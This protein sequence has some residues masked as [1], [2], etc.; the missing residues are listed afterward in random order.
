MKPKAR[1]LLYPWLF[2]R[3]RFRSD[4]SA[5]PCFKVVHAKGL[6]VLLLTAIPGV[7]QAQF[8]YATNDN[9]ITITGYTGPGGNVVIPSIIT[10]LPVTR[11]GDE[12]FYSVGN[13]LTNL[14]GVS[15]PQ[16]VT[17]IGKSAFMQCAGLT[18][19]NLPD[20][21]A[22][23]GDQAFCSCNSLT[24]LT[25]GKA[26]TTIRAGEGLPL[27]GTFQWCTSL[28]CLTI[29]DNVTNITDGYVHLGGSL[30]A[31][32]NCGL[33]N[34]VIGKGLAY[35]GT[36][37]F[38]WCQDLRSVFFRGNAPTTGV[39]YW[40]SN[41]VF[42]ASSLVMVYYLPGTTGWGDTLAGVPAVLWNPQIQTSDASFGVG[43]NGFEFNIVGTPDIPLVIE[44]SI[45]LAAQSWIALQ[46]CTLTNG[47]VR[48][49]DPQWANYPGRFYRIRSP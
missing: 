35:L 26:V 20:S 46:S 19:V 21:V 14:T 34:V 22:F 49:N 6:F 23:L 12:A 9:T 25:I 47:L 10:G 1:K 32:Y 37:A 31:F 7:M 18:N 15:I 13:P 2:S 24:S 33:T 40:G 29:P 36:G 30:G 3:C 45:D 39:S 41:D 38:N 48:F 8:T 17:S 11:I 43:P 44:A 28:T 4:V 5:V 42:H 16:S 27:Y